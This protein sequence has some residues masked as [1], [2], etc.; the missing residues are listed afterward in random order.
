M[1]RNIFR[2]TS[3]AVFTLAA[4]C[5]TAHAGE[6]MSWQDCVNRVTKQNPDIAAARQS[7]SSAQNQAKAAYSGF[8][9]QLTAS[10]NVTRGNSYSF[11]QTG[12]VPISTPTGDTSTSS[13]TLTLTQNIFAGFHDDSLVEQMHAT[14]TASA[15]SLDQVSAQVAFNLRTAFANLLY[16]QKYVNLTEQ[17][18]QRRK[19]NANLVEMHFES[20]SE[21]LGSVMLSKAFVE[22]ANYDRTVAHNAI[23]TSRQQLARVM[24]TDEA[25]AFVISGDMPLSEPGAEPDLK[26]IASATPSHRQS[27][28][29]AK[30]SRAA[31]LVSASNFY[32]N[33]GVTGA[34]SAQGNN[35]PPSTSKRSLMFNLSLPLINGGKDY[36]G[37]ESANAQYAAASYQKTSVDQQLLSTLKSTF[38]TYTEAVA[39]LKVDRAFLEAAEVRAEIARSKY[40]NGLLSFEDWDIIE[41]DLITKQKTFL[42]SE[43]DRSLAEANWELAKG[44]GVGE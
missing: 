34:V 4:I 15:A 20:G 32:P 12:G 22:Q 7:L 24:G 36:Y 13:V 2:I 14:S 35:G 29:Q 30:A 10:G 42:Q 39:K 17:I 6:Q 25:A 37:Y 27:E 3:A 19:E 31:V 1:H 11:P 23:G 5:V 9:P 26:Q 33:L 8:L 44:K 38:A 21:N 18:I 43:R 40:N 41:N 16:A 28:A